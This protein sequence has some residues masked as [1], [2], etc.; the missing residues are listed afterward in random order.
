[1][2]WFRW[3]RGT[4]EDGKFRAVA[5]N[6]GVTVATVIGVW[7]TLLEDAS[8]QNHR[9]IADAH[10]GIYAAVLDLDEAQVH[11]IMSALR[12]YGLVTVDD[13]ADQRIAIT[14]WNKRQFESD[15]KDPTNADRQR[16]Y[17]E[18]Q[19]QNA[20][21]L[22][23]NGDVTVTSLPDTDTETDTE[24]EKNARV[25]DADFDDWYAGYPH[26]VGKQA[27][28]LSYHRARNKTGREDLIAG[29]DAYVRTKPADRP[30]CNPATWLNQE[31]WLD[32]P[33][34]MAPVA[35]V[36]HRSSPAL[37]FRAAI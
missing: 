29:R 12:E 18:K 30:W 25:R 22:P 6:A 24:E 33:A 16:R 32:C 13:A 36:T 2:Q 4:V 3:Y 31:R 26:K 11:R 14:N 19:K 35:D 8:H 37:A 21:A 7:A 1:M 27:A 17:R 15:A 28:R 5:R 10:L 34:P 9:G 23:R 20:D